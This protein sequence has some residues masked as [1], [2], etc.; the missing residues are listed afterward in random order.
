MPPRLRLPGQANQCL[1][2]STTKPQIS[3]TQP[4]PRHYASISTLDDTPLISHH[5]PTQPPS[6]KPAEFRKT[7]LH[8]HYTSLLRSSPL[9]LIFQHNNLK[10]L[11]WAALRREL[12][13]AL[14]AVDAS[15][16]SSSSEDPTAP[17]PPST[18]TTVAD[19]AKLQIVQTGI[20]ASALKVVQHFQPEDGTPST[21]LS[22]QAWQAA[23]L[24]SRAAGGKTSTSDLSPLLSGPLALVSLPLVSPAHLRAVLETLAPSPE[25]KAP[26]RKAA[27]GLYEN[28]TQTGLQKL[29]LLGAR[30]DGRVFDTE[31]AKWIAGISGGIG[32]L[33]AQLVGLLQ[34][35]GVQV[36][37]T[38]EGAGKSLYVAMESRR[39]D[40]E[41]KTG[42][43]EGE[44]KSE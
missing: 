36:A 30:V 31:G 8:R 20:F 43:G 10:A 27:P 25:F 22:K 42:E 23:K 32:S 11:E 37:Q 19:T 9:L 16:L 7:Q 29:M 21:A 12:T 35:A 1:H 14:R 40:M 15:L 24:G 3:H 2:Q 38:L 39:I 41:E 13:L 26:K 4:T 28:V 18:T 33:R 17:P 34:G 5:P 44:K 6:Y